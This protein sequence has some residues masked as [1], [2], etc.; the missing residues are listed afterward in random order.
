MKAEER[1][2]EIIR[3][4]TVTD[5]AEA[6]CPHCGRRHKER[7]E[8]AK[9]A[10][11]TRL[12]R[13]EGRSSGFPGTLERR[14]ADEGY[15][16]K[17]RVATCEFGRTDPSGFELAVTLECPGDMASMYSRLHRMLAGWCVDCCAEQ[18]WEIP[19]PQLAV[20]QAG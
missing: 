3:E 11:L 19:C 7:S 17:C 6:I 5:A 2:E 8:E 20:H 4:D 1:P 14:L 18:G 16:D 12:R 15:G 10:L 9:K 13:A